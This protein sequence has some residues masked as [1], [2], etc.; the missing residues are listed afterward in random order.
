M[1]IIQ[2]HFEALLGK[3]QGATLTRNPD[4][5]AAVT[6]PGIKLPAGWNRLEVTVAFVAPAGYPQ[7]AP[8]CFWTEPDLALAHGGLPKNTGQ[9]HVTG[10]S[11]AWLWFSWH[12][13]VWNSNSDNL[14]TYLKVIFQRLKD[15][16]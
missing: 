1:P 13:S 8:D 14:E 5:S 15:A 3:H 2:R 6:V 11:P 9:N 10:I 12:P 4:G 16:L 7:A